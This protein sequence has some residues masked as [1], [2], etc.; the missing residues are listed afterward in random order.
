MLIAKLTPSV[1]IK[2]SFP[3]Q[4][5]QKLD[6]LLEKVMLLNL[7]LIIHILMLHV[8]IVIL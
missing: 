3:F 1:P 2:E 5:L 4:G 8:H 7:P 6:A